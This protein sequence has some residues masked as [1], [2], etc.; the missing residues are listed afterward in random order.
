MGNISIFNYEA[1]YLDY[2]EGNLSEKDAALLM[3]FLEAHPELKIEEESLPVLEM[4][5]ETLDRKFKADLKQIN[6]NETLINN[7]NIE[8]FFIADLEGLLSIDKKRELEQFADQDATFLRTQKIY[9]STVLVADQDIVYSDKNSLKQSK[10]IVLWPYIS[11]AAAASVALMFFFMNPSAPANIATHNA[12]KKPVTIKK[13]VPQILK[14]ESEKRKEEMGTKI[15]EVEF[16]SNSI[17]VNA[18]QNNKQDVAV[19]E[20]LVARPKVNKLLPR[21]IK[22]LDSPKSN[23]SII[24]NSNSGN[25]LANVS[26]EPEDDYNVLGFTEMNNPIKPITNRLATAVNQEVDFRTAKANEKQSG[27]FFI[28][29]GKLEISHRKF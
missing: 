26:N 16:K 23:N 25:T 27:G 29:V 22:E 7:E 17:P 6:F 15:N 8:Q 20:R 13:V 24:E 12:I 5:T 11:I 21:K 9:A 18:L 3:A 28:K 14:E 10:R 4:E 1:F 2:L 19:N